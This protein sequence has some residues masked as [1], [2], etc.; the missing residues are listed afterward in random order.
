MTYSGVVGMAVETRLDSSTKITVKNQLSGA[1][2]AL[3]GIS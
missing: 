1:H 3:K 2:Y